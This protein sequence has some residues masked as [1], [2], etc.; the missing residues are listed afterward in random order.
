MS[1]IE[2]LRASKRKTDSAEY[3]AGREDGVKWAMNR[4]EAFELQ[5]LEEL[6]AEIEDSPNCDWEEYFTDDSQTYS[7]AE[8]L[9]FSVHPE[10][11]G[12]RD[13]AKWFWDKAIG[14]DDQADRNR[15]SG[16]FLRGFADGAI[17][18]WLEVKDKI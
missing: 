18:F 1:A 9:Y 6:R 11:E 3:R 15:D 8:R 10:H 4:A 7:A 13:V 17:D 12:N 14:D 5:R 16:V 2:R